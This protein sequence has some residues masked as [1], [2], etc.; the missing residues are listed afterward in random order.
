MLL[1]CGLAEIWK[2]GDTGDCWLAKGR[3]SA[4][5]P[6]GV[7]AAEK[8]G[9]WVAVDCEKKVPA[10]VDEASEVEILGCR[11]PCGRVDVGLGLK[12]GPRTGRNASGG[13]SWRYLAF[14]LTP[15]WQLSINPRFMHRW[16]G[17]S[18]PKRRVSFGT[19]KGGR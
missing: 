17:L 9:N 15:S 1:V 18:S 19:K 14:F 10:V 2:G 8:R 11:W 7:W 6:I 16:H 13:A 5:L 3:L 12:F 4:R